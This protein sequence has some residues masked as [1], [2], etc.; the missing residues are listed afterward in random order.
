M[1]ELKKKFLNETFNVLVLIQYQCVIQTSAC[2]FLAMWTEEWM[3]A[4]CECGRLYF[5]NSYNYFIF[6]YILDY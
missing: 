3:L 1:K 5:F 6:N 2:G 4:L